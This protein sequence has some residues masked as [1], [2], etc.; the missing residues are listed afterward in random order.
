MSPERFRKLTATLDQRQPDLSLVMEGV[1]KPHNLSAVVRSCDA[2]GIFE[3]HATSEHKQVRLAQKTAGGNRRWMPVLTH[4][5]LDAAYKHLRN[6][7]F[8]ILAAH[9]D[10]AAADFRSVD[11]TQKVALVLGGE[12]KGLSEA[13]AND[14]DR[15][16][17]IP[18]QGMTGSLN[19]S[20]AAAVILFEAQR[21]RLAAGLYSER[22]LDADTYRETLLQWV[23]PK[24][25]EYCDAHGIERPELDGS[26]NLPVGFQINQTT[27]TTD[28]PAPPNP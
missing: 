17:T 12:R 13:A 14:A 4:V 21:Q 16:I 3:V 26:G 19:V 28:E 9:A 22:R 5:S 1:H 23:H 7:G 6:S 24:V 25:A 11:Y 10:P 18:T 2:V 8:T 27:R 20:V 15:C